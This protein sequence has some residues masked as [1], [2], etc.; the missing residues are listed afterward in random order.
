MDVL[1]SVISPRP[2]TQFNC[3]DEIIHQCPTEMDCTP[4]KS[5]RCRRIQGTAFARCQLSLAFLD[6]LKIASLVRVEQ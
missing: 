5:W 4:K 2:T 3:G 1:F 6:V